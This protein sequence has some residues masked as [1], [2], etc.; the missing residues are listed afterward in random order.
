MDGQFVKKETLETARIAARRPW[1]RKV[2]NL[3]QFAY[4]LLWTA[5][6]IHAGHGGAEA[7]R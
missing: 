6:C 4:T 5:G 3:L 7:D 2:W 1:W